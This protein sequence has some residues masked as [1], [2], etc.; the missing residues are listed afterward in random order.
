M[1]NEITDWFFPGQ[2]KKGN[3]LC[4]VP[5]IKHQNP[6]CVTRLKEAKKRQVSEILSSWCFICIQSEIFSCHWFLNPYAMWQ[7]GS[8]RVI[9]Q[10]YITYNSK[11]ELVVP[12]RLFLAKWSLFLLINFMSHL[13]SQRTSIENESEWIISGT[14]ASTMNKK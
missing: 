13:F 12:C 7:S 5:C 8:V 6:I 10:I 3:R 1:N 14:Q 11:K 4:T 9:E 2:Y